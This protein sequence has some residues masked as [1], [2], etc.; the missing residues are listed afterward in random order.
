MPGFL[1][2]DE[3]LAGTISGSVDILTELKFSQS[4]LICAEQLVC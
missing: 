1:R 4:S 3:M 2:Y